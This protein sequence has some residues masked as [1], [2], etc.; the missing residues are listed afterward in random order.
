MLKKRSGLTAS[1][2]DPLYD[3]SRL[4][5]II[6]KLNEFSKSNSCEQTGRNE[7]LDSGKTNST[8]IE[9]AGNNVGASGCIKAANEICKKIGGRTSEED[10]LKVLDS[11]SVYQL[12]VAQN[13]AAK[14]E[15][16]HVDLIK[17]L[18]IMLGVQKSRLDSIRGSRKEYEKQLKLYFDKQAKTLN[19]SVLPA[20][21]YDPQI[22]KKTKTGDSSGT[23]TR[24]SRF[25]PTTSIPP[26]KPIHSQNHVQS[27]IPDTHQPLPSNISAGV[28]SSNNL[29]AS[30]AAN[31]ICK[32]IG[33]RTSEEDVLKVLDSKSVYQLQVAQ[34]FAAKQE[35]L[36]VDLIK[37]LSIML[38][39]QKSRLDSIRG[40]RK[41]YE[42]QLKLYFDK[43]A[44]TL[45]TSV[46][47]APRYDPQISKKTKT[48]DSS[49]TGTRVSRFS[50]TTSI[51]PNKPI[52]S[53]N[54]VQ[55]TIPDTHQPLPSNIS[56]G[57]VSSNNLSA[58]PGISSSKVLP[59]NNIS[60]NEH[61]SYKTP[62]GKY[63]HEPSS[64]IFNKNSSN[65]FNSNN[66]STSLIINDDTNNDGSIGNS[67]S[68]T[69]SVEPSING[70]DSD[71][72]INGNTYNSHDV[73][74]NS[75][76]QEISR[77]NIPTQNNLPDDQLDSEL[78]VESNIEE[79]GYGIN[80]T[81]LPNSNSSDTDTNSKKRSFEEWE[82][83]N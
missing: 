78:V 15:S 28:V 16:L 49:G 70:S 64:T 6:L 54:H 12:Q 26:N 43:Q 29:S 48:G 71:N 30:P 40:S 41:E 60:V 65:E 23:G 10:V 56:A 4:E 25:S 44:K 50:P 53:Q 35:S 68:R 33:G 20:P 52:H 66:K 67:S 79:D 76:D 13:F 1:L 31:E 73:L 14:Q 72:K 55:S 34:N 57:V 38:G 82:F 47:P 11:K 19:T 5:E 59:S 45:N 74:A 22:S 9:E 81:R 32:K 83:F 42:K 24:V 27:T 21:R 63:V 36:H 2:K 18:S 7:D 39:V 75:N 51:P 37:E 58:S 62:I 80:E 77:A 3:I 46:L 69:G 8:N 61:K 17:E